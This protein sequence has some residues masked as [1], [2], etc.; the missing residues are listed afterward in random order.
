MPDSDQFS[1]NL[2]ELLDRSAVRLYGLL[3]ET[4]MFSREGAIF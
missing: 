3:I 2:T 1:V 4:I